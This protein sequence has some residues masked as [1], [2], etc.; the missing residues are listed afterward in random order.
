MGIKPLDAKISPT[1]I[2]PDIFSDI[3]WYLSGGW[4]YFQEDATVIKVDNTFEGIQMENQ[5][6]QCRTYLEAFVF[7]PQEQRLSGF[8]FEKTGQSL[9]HDRKGESL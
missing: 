7:M 4:G 3:D 8:S 5:F 2:L 1:L 6:L 9:F